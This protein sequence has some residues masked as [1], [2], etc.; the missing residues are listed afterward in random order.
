MH[1]A[2]ISY[3][4]QCTLGHPACTDILVTLIFKTWTYSLLHYNSST[5]HSQ[6]IT[7]AIALH[8][9]VYRNTESI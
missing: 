3:S 4:F 9:H 6:G 5:I 1:A 2:L 8:V 7:Y